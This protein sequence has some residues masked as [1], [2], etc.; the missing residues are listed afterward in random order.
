MT[1]ESNDDGLTDVSPTGM[2]KKKKKISEDM[3]I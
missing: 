1:D 3:Y 2:S